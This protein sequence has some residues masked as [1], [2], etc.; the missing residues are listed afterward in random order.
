MGVTGG[1]AVQAPPVTLADRILGLA[2]ITRLDSCLMAMLYTLLGVHLAAGPSQILSARALHASFV[3]LLVVAFGFV[4]N[5]Y[6]DVVADGYGKPDRPIPS[7]RISRTAAGRLA[8]LLAVC[9]VVSAWRLGPAMLG[10]AL[11][12]VL[13]SA[14]Y[15]YSLKDTLLLGNAAMAGLNAT[16]VLY[17]A[18]AVGPI[19]AGA[20]AAS[21]LILL[22]TFSQEI[23]YAVEDHDGDRRAGLRTTATRLG[24]RAALGLYR[25]CALAFVAAALVPWFLDIGSDRYLYAI[26][27]CSVLP[28]IGVVVMLTIRVDA[29]TIRYAVY[30]TWYVWF[31]SIIPIVLLRS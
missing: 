5:D 7:G 29:R 26:A 17:G 20:W 27:T 3:V 1:S 4:V 22:Y 9:A 10:I 15:S 25:A 14:V 6:R 16:I 2:Q 24:A 12:T 13:L 11:G 8:G 21:V 28:T 23:L 30:L 31:T 18:L 19:T